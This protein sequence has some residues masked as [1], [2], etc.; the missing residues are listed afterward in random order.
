MP[1]WAFIHG[2][3]CSWLKAAHVLYHSLLLAI[4]LALHISKMA[5][6][7]VNIHRSHK[8]FL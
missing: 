5:H 8:S 2:A 3:W 7:A 1:E 6:A 4:S